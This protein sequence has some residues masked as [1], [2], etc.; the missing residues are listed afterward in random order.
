[1]YINFLSIIIKIC[2]YNLLYKFANKILYILLGCASVA[3]KDIRTLGTT[4]LLLV[5]NRPHGGSRNGR[6]QISQARWRYVSLDVKTDWVH[7]RAL[8]LQ[9]VRDVLPCK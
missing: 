2:L 7:Y 3:A 8:N 6:P 1:M 9:Y 4:W 5:S